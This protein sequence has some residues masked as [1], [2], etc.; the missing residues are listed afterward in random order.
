M[1]LRS[2]FETLSSAL[3]SINCQNQRATFQSYLITMTFL[4]V[5]TTTQRRRDLCIGMYTSLM[6]CWRAPWRAPEMLLWCSSPWVSASCKCGEIQGHFDIARPL[7][8]S[9]WITYSLRYSE[10][11]RYLTSRPYHRWLAV[12]SQTRQGGIALKIRRET[13]LCVWRYGNSWSGAGKPVLPRGR[14]GRQTEGT[15]IMHAVQ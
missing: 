14:A 12:V 5:L 10:K 7:T 13:S 11:F 4:H 3:N 8:P 15:Y 6:D 2:Y 1:H 9:I